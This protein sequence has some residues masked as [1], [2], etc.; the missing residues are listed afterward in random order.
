[1]AA[2]GWAVGVGLVSALAGAL[3]LLLAGPTTL[4]QGAGVVLLL[5]SPIL[6]ISTGVVVAAS[7]RRT[8]HPAAG[9]ATAT[10]GG[11]AGAP[12][13]PPIGFVRLGYYKLKG[14]TADGVAR[15]LQSEMKLVLGG[16]AG[17]VGCLI[18]RAG[19]DELISVSQW[20]TRQ[21]AEAAVDRELR[22]MKS[23]VA[24][25]VLQTESHVGAVVGAQ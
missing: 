9:H 1:M 3:L 17:Y 11:L 6:A 19:S 4:G 21:Q 22:W 5:A 10:G 2:L 25:T 15:R 7:H 24:A 23:T 16:E 20:L 18:V 12:P 13:L 8:R 14:G